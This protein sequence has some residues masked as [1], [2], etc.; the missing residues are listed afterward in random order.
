MIKVLPQTL[1]GHEICRVT[2]W[3]QF[4]FDVLQPGKGVIRARELLRPHILTSVCS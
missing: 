3:E 1:I 4:N 2:T